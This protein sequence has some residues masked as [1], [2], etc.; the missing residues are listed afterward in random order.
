MNNYKILTNFP[1][2]NNSYTFVNSP[3]EIATTTFFNKS[4]FIKLIL[5]LLLYFLYTSH[6]FTYKIKEQNIVENE[7]KYL[8]IQSVL[9]Y[10]FNSTYI[11]NEMGT[12]G[13]Y[14]IYKVPQISLILTNFDILRIEDEKKLTNGIRFITEQN[15]KNIEVIIY[16]TNITKKEFKKFKEK[17]KNIFPRKTF[18]FIFRENENEVN[19]SDLINELKGKIR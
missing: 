8:D 19:Y 18:K 11:K 17:Y 15:Y 13:L 10:T 5:L 9:N 14:N 3:K 7:E 6:F 12:Y 2:N 4:N 1:K 16:I